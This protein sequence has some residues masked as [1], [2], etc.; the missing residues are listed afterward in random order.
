MH[1]IKGQYGTVTLKEWD[2]FS[3]FQ[4]VES[5]WWM[6]CEEVSTVR[7]PISCGQHLCS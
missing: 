7:A 1:V 2:S 3:V 5:K 4:V 6:G